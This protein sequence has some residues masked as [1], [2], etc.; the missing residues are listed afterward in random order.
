MTIAKI[1]VGCATY[2]IDRPYDYLVPAELKQPLR[3]GMRVLVPF[4]S[5]NR[6][7]DGIVLAVQ[8]RESGEGPKLKTVLALLDESPVLD[9]EL[10]QLALWMRERCF[11]TVYDAARAILPAG[12]WF[13]IQDCWRL[14][15]GVDREAAYE[16]AGN[17]KNARRLVE[18]LFANSRPMEMRQIREAFGT[19]DPWPAI[20]LLEG[21]GAICRETS[22][23]RGIGDKVEQIATLAVPPEEAMAQLE[24]GRRRAPLQYSVMEQ[25]CVFGSVSVKELCYFTGASPATL[26]A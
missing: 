1:A 18:L 19:G 17:S 10:L 13:S 2:P 21:K 12:L 9:G 8:E 25:L 20:R 14:A 4:G 22:A 16:S 24:P 7:T 15:D 6:R 3:P 11:C 5:G 23:D 26:R